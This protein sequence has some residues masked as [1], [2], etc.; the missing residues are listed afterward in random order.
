[1]KESFFV[2]TIK[3]IG[4]LIKCISDMNN[5]FGSQYMICGM[6]YGAMKKGAELRKDWQEDLNE[7]VRKAWMQDCLRDSI[8]PSTRLPDKRFCFITTNSMEDFF[9]FFYIFEPGFRCIKESIFD[10]IDFITEQNIEEI[11]KQVKENLM[12]EN[13]KREVFLNTVLSRFGSLV[14]EK[15]K[16]F[17]HNKFSQILEE[18]KSNADLFENAFLL[19]QACGDNTKEGN[20]SDLLDAIKS[21]F[22]LYDSGVILISKFFQFLYVK[23]KKDIYF[24]FFRKTNEDCIAIEKEKN[25]IYKRLKSQRVRIEYD[26][27]INNIFVP[28]SSEDLASQYIKDCLVFCTRTAEISL[29]SK[30]GKS[31]P[32]F[33]FTGILTDELKIFRPAFMF[34]ESAIY[35]GYGFCNKTISDFIEYGGINANLRIFQFSY[36]DLSFFFP[37]FLLNYAD[38]LIGSSVPKSLSEIASKEHV[39]ISDQTKELIDHSSFNK[40]IWTDFLHEI[41]KVYVKRNNFNSKLYISVFEISLESF[42]EIYYSFIKELKKNQEMFLVSDQE[43]EKCREFFLRCILYKIKSITNCFKLTNV[44]AIDVEIIKA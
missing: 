33:L 31:N 35:F 18:N 36:I 17:L 16:S 15:L 43:I 14:I 10:T 3:L 29:N 13:I 27:D 1:M 8:N 44:P 34:S 2:G 32:R 26:A 7:S 28:F 11:Q 42:K 4:L 5:S 9:D 19:I 20:F 24:N 40:S 39:C 25:L 38:R 22:F 23:S 6:I 30:L 37:E 12:K 41:Y 21:R